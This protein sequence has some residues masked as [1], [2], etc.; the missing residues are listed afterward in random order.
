MLLPQREMGGLPT[1]K[2]IATERRDS[3]ALL[4]SVVSGMLFGKRCGGSGGSEWGAKKQSIA[5]RD[6]HHSRHREKEVQTVHDGARA[7]GPR[8]PSLRI[9]REKKD[10]KRKNKEAKRPLAEA[11]FA[12]ARSGRCA[13]RV[14]HC[15]YQADGGGGTVLG[16]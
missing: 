1:P 13:A 10:E 6:G 14:D 16:T 9:P 3:G 2:A 11:G 4:G 12:G 15:G 8:R 5:C 7:V